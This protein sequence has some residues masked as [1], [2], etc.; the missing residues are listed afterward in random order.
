MKKVRI[1][2]EDGWQ[3]IGEVSDEDA[4][5]LKSMDGPGISASEFRGLSLDAMERTWMWD[6]AGKTVMI[7]RTICHTGAYIVRLLLK[8]LKTFPTAGLVTAAGR[9]I[10]MLLHAIPLVGWLLSAIWGPVMLVLTGA[11]L[12]VDVMQLLKDPD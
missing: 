11:A 3:T 2:E 9:V 7:G 12:C 5:S 4:A 10:G 6:L 1:R 8:A